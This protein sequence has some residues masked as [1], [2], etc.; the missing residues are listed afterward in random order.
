[1][2]IKKLNQNDVYQ[3]KLHELISLRDAAE[4]SGFAQGYLSYLIRH[5]K[6]WGKKIGRNWVTTSR[7]VDEY[8]SRGIKPGPKSQKK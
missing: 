3:A 4:Q 6:I 7:A 8:L 2:N 1:M 5:G